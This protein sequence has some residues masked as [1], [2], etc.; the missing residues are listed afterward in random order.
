[1]NGVGSDDTV[2]VPALLPHNVSDLMDV[3][4]RVS[5]TERNNR[6]RWVAQHVELSVKFSPDTSCN[7]LGSVDDLAAGLQV[8]A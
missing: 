5:R 1:M 3:A 4:F 2:K 6:R 7:R 8:A